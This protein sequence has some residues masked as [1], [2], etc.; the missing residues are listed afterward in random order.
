[1]EKSC[2]SL[3]RYISKITNRGE[4]G[5]ESSSHLVALKEQIF[6]DTRLEVEQLIE[7]A[8]KTKTNE[9]LEL[10]KSNFLNNTNF[11]NF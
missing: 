9:F 6:Q 7:E 5:G 2:D 11:N 3:E 1:M 8:L 10:G 4:I